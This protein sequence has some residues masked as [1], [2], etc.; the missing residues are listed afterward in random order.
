M[1]R[2]Q[3]ADWLDALE[4]RAPAGRIELGLERVARV[5]QA[6]GL[7]LG[8][9][10]VITVAG[11]NGKGSVVAMLES[12]LVAAGHRPLAYTSPHLI[13]FA[14]RIRL[15]GINADPGVILGALQRV[16]SARGDTPL[17]YFEHIT[18]AAL[19]LAIEDDTDV[20]VLEVGLGGRLDAVNIVDADVAVITSIGLDHAEWLGRTRSAIGREKAG[21]ARRGRPVVVGERRPPA[22]LLDELETIGAR[23]MRIGRDVRWRRRD[24][25]FQV[26]AQGRRYDLPAPALPGPWQF[27]NAACA[28]AAL[29]ALGERLPVPVQAMSD[30]LSRVRLPGRFQRLGSHPDIILDVAHN[31]PAARALAGA[32]GPPHGRST[33]VFSALEGKDVRAIGRALDGC[34]SDWLVSGLNGDRGR[35][36]EAIAAEL[37]S[38]PVAGRLETVESVPAA[39]HRGLAYSGVD[40]RL[41]VF[42]SFVTAAEAWPVLTQRL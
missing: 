28:V 37:A 21:V 39:I 40:D 7:D 9:R 5:W 34:F 14:E 33:A 25:G 19:G 22:G 16:E 6:M 30:G 18:L 31:A 32:L 20:L 23:V 15:G 42:G 2:Q 38:V 36:A 24:A 27:D 26:T 17:T 8:D 41:V 3:L 1:S 4:R 12:M 10:P 29:V 11:T 35:Q 13:D